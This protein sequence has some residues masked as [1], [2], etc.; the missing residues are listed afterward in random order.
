MAKANASL[1]QIQIPHYAE[2]H[3]YSY[4]P[5]PLRI[6]AGLQLNKTSIFVVA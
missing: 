3:R 4:N 6:A 5:Q 1:L 2:H